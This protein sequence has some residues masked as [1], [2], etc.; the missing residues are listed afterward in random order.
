MD[1]R[2]GGREGGEVDGALLEMVKGVDMCVSC[3]GC[4]GLDSMDKVG[5]AAFFEE[6]ENKKK[7]ISCD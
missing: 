7:K 5:A 4:D 6:K 2:E 3:V 1:R